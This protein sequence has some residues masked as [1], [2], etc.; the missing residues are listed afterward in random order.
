MTQPVCYTVSGAKIDDFRLITELL[1]QSDSHIYGPLDDK[2]RPRNEA[3]MRRC[4]LD[5]SNVFC[6]GNILVASVHGPALGMAVVLPAGRALRFSAPE[7]T[8]GLPQAESIDFVSRGYFDKLLVE[9][10]AMEGTYINSIAVLPGWRRRGLAKALLG[11]IGANCSHPQIIDVLDDNLPAIA[12]YWQ[13]GFV[14]ASR[15]EAYAGRSSGKLACIR[16]RR[17][18]WP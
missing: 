2:G 13:A 4:M 17:D 1:A 9:L 12:A 7:L 11:Y 5:P 3:F 14:E 18:N 6:L 10:L 16:M 15:F 8:R